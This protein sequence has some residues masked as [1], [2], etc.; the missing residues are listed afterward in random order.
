LRSLMAPMVLATGCGL[1]GKNEVCIDTGCWSA[2]PESVFI[3]LDPSSD[4]W[5]AGTYTFTVGLDETV[6]TCT[7]TVGEEDERT[8]S[9][10]LVALGGVSS[11]TGEDTEV[12][13]NFLQVNAVP[14]SLSLQVSRDGAEIA[15]E[16]FTLEIDESDYPAPDPDDPCIET[17]PDEV[18]LDF[19]LAR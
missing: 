12:R 13:V 2:Y 6:V 8:C 19:A 11:G 7:L 16:T 15:S 17:C 5:A 1:L 14:D 10:D 18:R 9:S 3:S 4:E